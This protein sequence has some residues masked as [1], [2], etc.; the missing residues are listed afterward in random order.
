MVLQPFVRPWPLFQILNVF[1]RRTQWRRMNCLRSLERWDR[2]FQSHSSHGCLCVRS[3]CVCVVLC[4]GSG[5]GP[6]KGCRT[7]GDD[8][9]D[10][11]DDESYYTVGSTPW[12]GDQPVARLLPAHRTTQTQNKRTQAFIAQVG[13]EPTIPVFERAKAVHALERMATVTGRI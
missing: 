6:T 8:D 13:F 3:F 11:E 9:D 2:G 10:D 4:V 5:Q 7:I 12:T 1:T